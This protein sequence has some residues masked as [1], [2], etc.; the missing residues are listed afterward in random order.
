MAVVNVNAVEKAREAKKELFGLLKAK[1]WLR[2][3]GLTKVRGKPALRVNVKAMTRQV[4]ASIP[5]TVQGVQVTVAA[6]GDIHAL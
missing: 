1:S 4:R 5:R 3:I 6:I 2:G